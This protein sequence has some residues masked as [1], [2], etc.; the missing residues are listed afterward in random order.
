MIFKVIEFRRFLLGCSA[1]VVSSCASTTA[2]AQDTQ[3][4]EW[5]TAYRYDGEGHV[6]GV[7]LPD[8]DGSDGPLKYA[9][10]RT[11][12]NTLG[13][14]VSVETGELATWQPSSVAPNS[15]PNF[16]VNK[17]EYSEYDTLGNLVKTRSADATGTSLAVKHVIYDRLGRTICTATRMDPAQWGGQTNACKPQTS[18]GN[19]PDRITRN[20]YDEVGQLRRVSK[21]VGTPLEQIYAEYSYS[22]NGKRESVTDANRNRAELRY[23]GFDRQIEWH[24]PSKTTANTASSDD[25]E[26]Y[27]YDN[28]GNRTA[29]RKRDGRVLN[30]SYDSLN[31]MTAKFIPDGCAPIQFG[32]CLDGSKTRD[33]YYDYD[34]RGL[35]TYA[36]FDNSLGEGV[37]NV[38]D[39]FG[40]IASSITTLGG[41]TRASSNLY[42][43]GGNRIQLTYPDG[44]VARYIFDRR[45]RLTAIRDSAGNDLTVLTYYANGSRGWLGYGA[46]GIGYGYDA[47][48]R[49]TGYNLQRK[50]NG[51]V[52]ADSATLAYNAASQIREQT[53]SND[54]Y[55]W[56]GAVNIDRPYGING[57]NQYTGAGANKFSYDG[58]GNLISEAEQ[59]F[60][61]DAENRL[62]S[63]AGAR[64]AILDY[65]P[66]GRLWQVGTPGSTST[67][68]TY[69]G[70]R[71]IAEYDGSG[72]LLNRY[73]H[74]TGTDEPVLWYERSNQIPRQLFADHHGSIIGI[75]EQGGSLVNINTYDEYGIPG[76]YNKG[77][78]Q[79]TGQMWLPELGMYYYKARIY[80]PTLGRFLQ[81][82]PIG[83]DDQLNLYAYVGNDPIN[84]RDP[85]GNSGEFWNGFS[86]SVAKLT[87]RFM[88][89][90]RR[91][92]SQ[93]QDIPR[94][95]KAL[96]RTA[97]TVVDTK[98]ADI[99]SSNLD[100][101]SGKQGAVDKVVRIG[102]NNAQY[103]DFIGAARESAGFSTG[104]NHRTEMLQSISGLDAKAV[105]FRQWALN[106]KN[107]LGIVTRAGLLSMADYSS[108]LSS[109]MSDALR[110]EED[111]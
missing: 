10:T 88:D 6:V 29:L 68:F 23:D 63:A 97:S 31:R 18:G 110:T 24:F 26:A 1:I 15:W 5:S 28:N 16:S 89:E 22:A 53:R 40:A 8:P 61:Y 99:I 100:L 108:R 81:N 56:N 70:D 83:Y 50:E 107:G 9:A 78:F 59:S 39:G 104:A 38:Y 41:V 106:P 69:D 92:N 13:Q 57:L 77:R 102:K 12:W 58:N 91:I 3:P 80:S 86:N 47:L 66:L 20:E 48:T 60:V 71:L 93:I 33:V 105:N 65:D 46:N 67:R 36:R 2:S 98:L 55:A 14:I 27:A 42:D 19:G 79:Y 35:Q 82:D 75:T 34:L 54:A 25:Y 95:E 17:I 37:A 44:T 4:S 76:L 51:L 21:A 111:D 11:R 90:T 96:E 30:F 103:K 45:N 32:A 43:S 101:D 84:G 52:V 85:S 7:I 109:R 74:A 87:I 73:I 72:E 49:L 94:Q 64:N 62:V